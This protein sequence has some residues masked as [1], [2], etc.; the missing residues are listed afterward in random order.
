MPATFG[1]ATFANYKFSLYCTYTPGSSGKTLGNTDV[2]SSIDMDGYRRALPITFTEAGN[3]S[4]IS[5]YHSAG[6]GSLLLGVYGDQSGSPSS[7]LGVTPTTVVSATEGWQTVS[8]TSPVAVTT[9]QTVWLSYVFET[10][11]G[12]RYVAG[13]PARALA[14]TAWAGGMPATYGAATFANYKFSLY[15][16]YTT[17]PFLN[18]SPSN[19]DVSSD[20]GSTTFSISSNTNWTVFEEAGWLTVSTSNGSGNVTITATLQANPSS[21]SRTATITVSGIGVDPQIVTVNQSRIADIDGN[22]Y[23]TIKIGSQIW[24]AENLKTT[25]YS[26]GDSVSSEIYGNDF[27]NLAIYGRLYCWPADYNHRNVCPTGWH[28]PSIN[29]WAILSNFLGGD[30]IAGG[31]LKETGTT[32]WNSPNT[33]ATNESFFTALP[34]GYL[35]QIGD[36][37]GIGNFGCWWSNTNGENTYVKYMAWSQWLH[38]DQSNVQKRNNFKNSHL[39]IRCIKDIGPTLTTD[40]LSNITI[41]PDNIYWFIY[42]A[43]SGGHVE[44][45][46]GSPITH[47]GICW[48]Y[49]GNPEINDLHTD[50]GGGSENFKSTLSFHDPVGSGY[51]NIC[52]RAYAT[53]GDGTG[54]GNEISYRISSLQPT[55]KTLGYTNGAGVA[56][57]SGDQFD[58]NSNKSVKGIEPNPTDI[59]KEKVLIYPNPAKGSVTVKWETCYEDRLTL[60]IY[61]LQGTPVKT[62]QIEPEINEIQVDLNDIK[63]G[64]YLFELKETK[65]GL[66][67]NRSRI[68]KL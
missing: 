59:S 38:Y 5:I 27:N 1:A 14:T 65:N 34:G 52:I 8:L 49:E 29:E 39:S 55:T 45:D 32:H 20:A 31:K 40:S 22:Y 25:K 18:V 15:C 54:Y 62:V 19:R 23:S 3:I 26:N 9:G 7:R 41:A 17:K 16:T 13:T 43:I 30:S 67:I 6:T 21:T 50:E 48:N 56:K 53:N 2:Y 33:G 61:N 4:S 44:N 11:P 36:F 37:G 57:S 47:K 60:T 12:V 64:I 28:V 66:I 63:D 46:N 58:I 10:N 68:V 24:M 42:T 35:S 51:F